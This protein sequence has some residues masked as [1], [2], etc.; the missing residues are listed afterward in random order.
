MTTETMMKPTFPIRK[1]NRLP[2]FDYTQNGAY[3][4]TVCTR[5]RETLFGVVGAATCRPQEK[6]HTLAAPRCPQETLGS[7]QVTLSDIGKTVESAILQIPLVYP[8][9]T[10]ERYIVMPDHIHLILMFHASDT[11]GRQVAA[12]TVSMIV[13]NMKRYVSKEIGRSVWQKGF[14]DHVIRGEKD[15][16]ETM[17]YIDNNPVRWMEKHGKVPDPI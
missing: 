4:I 6:N 8:S 12:P 5:D 16:I 15:Y 13:G 10:V 1:P 11:D 9:V 17:Q 7:P 3:F 14:Y 2:D